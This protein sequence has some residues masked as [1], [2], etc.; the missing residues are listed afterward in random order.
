MRLAALVDSPD[1]VC[2]RYRLR[3]F[4]PILRS[5]GHELTY[6]ADPATISGRLAVLRAISNYDVVVLQRRLPPFWERLMLSRNSKRLLFDLDDAVWL[7]DS[8][9]GKGFHSSKRSRRF[10][11]LMPRIS[12]AVAGNSY[13]AEACIKAKV[14]SHVV[15]PTCVD[16]RNYPVAKH[17]AEK[18]SLVW[19]GS[20]STLQGIEAMRPLW[21]RLG[22]EIPNIEMRIICDRF[23]KFEKMPVVAIPWSEATERLELAASSIGISWIPDDPWSR[24]KCGLKLLQSMAAGLPVVANAVGVHPE[25]I[26]HGV[27]GYLANSSDDWAEAIRKLSQD[28]AMRIEIGANARKVVLQRYSVEHGADLWMQVLDSL[29]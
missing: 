28:R 10:K 25:M 27:T 7:R 8:F 24:G 16:V 26:D 2:C 18:I 15:I 13:L 14:G 5:K 9:S 29:A 3:A 20:S 12:I 17:S 1:H 21:E 22:S 4:E 11:S 19:I 6:F 23:P